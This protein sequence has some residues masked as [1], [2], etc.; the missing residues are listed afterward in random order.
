[1]SLLST[2]VAVGP[3]TAVLAERAPAERI[4][5]MPSLTPALLHGNG[6]VRLHPCRT[7][8]GGGLRP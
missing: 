4:C 6:P 7:W 5:F 1:M 8:P 2:G 3:T